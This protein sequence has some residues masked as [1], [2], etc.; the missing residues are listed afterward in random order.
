MRRPLH[1][2]RGFTLVELLVVIA[3]I[4]VLVGLLLP[5]VQAARESGR[6]ATCSNNQYQMAF[7]AIRFDQ[8]NGYV[9][10]WRN[11]SPIPG[12]T[13][14][15]GSTTSYNTTYSWPVALLPLMERRDITQNPAGILGIYIG[16]FNCPSSPPDTM[17]AP[18][19]A[20]A[21]N[22]GS[23]DNSTPMRAAD[24]VMGDTTPRWVNNRL[25][26]VNIPSFDDI[27]N[28]DGTP[29][30]LLLSERCGPGVTG[31][32]TGMS[33]WHQQ[34]TGIVANNTTTL[35]TGFGFSN[36]AVVNAPAPGFGI[37][38]PTLSQSFTAAS[39]TNPSPTLIR[40]INNKDNYTS[41]GCVSQPSSNHPGGAVAAFCDGHTQFIKESCGA[42]VYAKLISPD[43]NSSS[44]GPSGFATI[45]GSS[46]WSTANYSVLN[47]ADY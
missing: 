6:R 1:P 46:G 47:E 27:S 13:T 22:I 15:S 3:I 45:T 33:A 2:F 17:T 29:T 5:A 10:G 41:P 32:S 9:P 38:V 31:N 12:H 20:Y 24:G 25:Q 43:D 30:T 36:A 40:I 34:W 21:G 35:A 42:A 16:F 7:A 18:T 28:R 19:L 23:G 44:I 14:G 8:A 11:P 39:G 37:W 26:R 4:G